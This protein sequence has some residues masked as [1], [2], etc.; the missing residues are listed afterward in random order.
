MPH[1]QGLSNNPYPELNLH[2]SS[3]WNLHKGLCPVGPVKILKAL[4]PS[5]I[6]STWP[7]HLNLLDLLT[8]KG[9]N[10]EVPHCRAFST[11]FTMQELIQHTWVFSRS[12][13]MPCASFSMLDDPVNGQNNT[14]PLPI[15]I[16]SGP[17][18]S[19][20]GCFQISLACAP[21]LI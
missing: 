14:S 5:S 19:P 15:L 1:S 2:N 9:T 7:T 8:L 20:Q 12:F 13:S 21:A 18:Y 4:L 3:Y 10:Y 17:K 16:P 11:H 6:L